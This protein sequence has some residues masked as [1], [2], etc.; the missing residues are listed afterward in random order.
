[1]ILRAALLAFCFVALPANA[2]SLRGQ[3]DIQMP[4]KLASVVLLIDAERRATWDWRAERGPGKTL[5][6][7]IAHNDGREVSIVLTD[8]AR[9]FRLSCAIQASDLWHCHLYFQQE[10][11]AVDGLIATRVGPGPLTLARQ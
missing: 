10:Q 8:R 1:M 3:W 11:T 7:Y 4:N 9:V 5:Y 6:G 2:Q